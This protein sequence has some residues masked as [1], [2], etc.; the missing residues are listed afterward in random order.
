MSR[1][2]IAALLALSAVLSLEAEAAE[3]VLPVSQ[4]VAPYSFVPTLPRYNNPTL[5]AFVALD[6]NEIPHAFETYLRFPSLAGL[7]PP[8]EVVE[9][10]ELL[11]YYAFDFEGFGETSTLPGDL[12]CHEVTGAWTQTSLTWNNRPPVAP[13]AADS[14]LGI[15]AFGPNVCDVTP[16]VQAWA[17]GLRPDHGVAVLSPTPRVIGIH[18]SEAAVAA[19]FKP[20]LIVNTAPASPTVLPALS[21][22]GLVLLVA[23]LAGLGAVAGSPRAAR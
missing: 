9:S 1:I 23:S 5:Y 15:T 16:V 21:T 3:L 8:G 6:E 18:A 17:A 11:L 7:I 22:T 19:V 20:T 2:P 10:A 14:I 4:D 12:H 13:I